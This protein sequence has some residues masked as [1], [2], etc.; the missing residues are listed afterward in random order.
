MASTDLHI[1][2]QSLKYEKLSQNFLMSIYFTVRSDLLSSNFIS[3]KTPQFAI[4]KFMNIVKHI[5][6]CPKNSMYQYQ[7][8]ANLLQFNVSYIYL[9]DPHIPF[10]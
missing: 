3:S 10:E 2:I 4:R 1:C 9:Y 7:Y 5:K 6:F 8:R